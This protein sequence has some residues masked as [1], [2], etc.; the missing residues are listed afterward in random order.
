MRQILEILM[1]ERAK[2]QRVKET[3]LLVIDT[4]TL[5]PETVTAVRELVTRCRA[6][7]TILIYRFTSSKTATALANAIAI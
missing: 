5:F 4:E 6:A 1:A 3:D 7:R 2:D